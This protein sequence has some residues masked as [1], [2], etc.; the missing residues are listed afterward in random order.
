MKAR[1][2]IWLIVIVDADNGTVARRIGQMDAALAQF[3]EPRTQTLRIRDEK[4]AR[5]VPRRNVETWIKALNSENVD[6]TEDYKYDRSS[7]EWLSLI[8]DAVAS[9]YALT[10]P[11]AALPTNLIDSLRHGAQEMNHLFQLAR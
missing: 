4:I 3:P 11:N 7:E 2:H 8:P 5:L 6:E 10:R 1:K 9:F